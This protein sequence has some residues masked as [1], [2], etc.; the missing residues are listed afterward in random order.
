MK[1]RAWLFLLFF[2]ATSVFAQAVKD[3]VFFGD[4]LSDN[5][6]LYR[7]V[8]IV[9]KSPPYYE[10]RFSNG[11]TWAEWVS[12][13][14]HQK[15][16]MEAQNYAVGGATT[17]F[18]G[19]IGAVPY[20]LSMEVSSY[21]KQAQKNDRASTLYFIWI[22]AND[23]FDEKSQAPDLL[24]AE[25]MNGI[26]SQ[27]RLLIENGGRQFVFLDLPDFAKVPFT[28]HLSQAEINRFQT[29]NQLHHK[30]LQDSVNYLK[31]VYPKYAFLYVDVYSIFSDLMENISFYNQKYGK[32]I[33][34][35]TESCWT[36]GYRLT[37]GDNTEAASFAHSVTLTEAYRVGVAQGFGEAAC[38]DPDGYLFWDK[39]HPTAVMHQVVAS[40]MIDILE[41]EWTGLAD[42]K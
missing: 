32:T 26:L 4:S 29:L 11:P 35:T 12:D 37:P 2:V 34:N 23:Y 41:K 27:V 30:K 28:Q 39:M 19:V 20:D 1:K 10:G 33:Y 21:L 13:Y 31:K 16:Q 7:W 38:P 15:Y 17:I 3:L 40:M 36:G 18:R 8:K 9:P 24:V 42:K 22:G 6:N 25:V 14:F 5:G